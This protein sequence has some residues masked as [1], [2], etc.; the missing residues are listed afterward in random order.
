MIRKTFWFAVVFC[1][2]FLAAQFASAQCGPGGCP[3][4]GQGGKFS[5]PQNPG[6][7]FNFRYDRPEGKFDAAVRIKCEDR[8]G[9]G[10]LGSGVVVKWG[11]RVVVVTARHVI[12]DARKIFIVIKGTRKVSASVIA[13]SAWDCAILQPDEVL[14]EV[15]PAEM[16]NAEDLSFIRS[17][18]LTSCGSGDPSGK[19]AINIGHFVG[20]MTN[21][22][23]NDGCSDWIVISGPARG[24]D[25]GGP[26][27][28]KSGKVAGILWG[29]DNV[30]VVGVY[31]SRVGLTLN[32]A[33]PNYKEKLYLETAESDLLA[34]LVPV[35]G[36]KAAAGK[37]SEMPSPQG[38]GDYLLPY[39]NE[40]AGREQA[41]AEVAKALLEAT[42]QN[43]A[44]LAEI[45][46]MQKEGLEKEQA[47]PPLAPVAPVAPVAPP[48][49]DKPSLKERIGDRIDARKDAI[50]DGIDAIVGSDFARRALILAVILGVIWWAINRHRKAGT[51]THIARAI[52]A[53]TTATSG[54]PVLGQ[55]TSVIDRVSDAAGDKIRDLQEKL[56]AKHAEAEAKKAEL[57]VQK[58]LTKVALATPAPAQ[59]PQ[60]APVNTGIG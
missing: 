34:P 22:K 60:A 38:G 46:R 45:L 11:S 26:I 56:A 5:K 14:T 58:E 21:D 19:F 29:T 3:K 8:K 2:A 27:Y 35:V 16:A 18:E 15:V 36:W 48:V 23:V 54:I 20:F 41:T 28:T 40:Q 47:S 44:M 30:A 39:R 53:V 57:A 1:I 42:R 4:A 7:T 24:G 6:G 10:S 13:D 12:V 50:A 49:E 31:A 55:V 52:D 37:Q 32:E 43:S 25:S 59:V 51:P 9:G 33:M 17:E